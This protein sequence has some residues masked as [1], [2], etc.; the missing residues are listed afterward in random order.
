[1]LIGVSGDG[2]GNSGFTADTT[3]T[4][5]TDAPLN[6]GLTPLR[7]NGG[8][9]VGATGSSITLG[10]EWLLNSSPALNKGVAE[11]APTTDERG[12]S[13]PDAATH[14]VDI[15]AFE[16]Q[17]VTLSVSVKASS[18]GV[19]VGN[20]A[21]FTI[22]VTNSGKVALPVDNSTVTVTLPSG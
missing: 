6:A 18:T 5:T 9:T 11:G 20:T 3:Q 19:A 1:N 17:H 10:T 13:R 15:G 4:G 22:T 21:S 2:G 8:P 14:L 12:F 7:N 16:A